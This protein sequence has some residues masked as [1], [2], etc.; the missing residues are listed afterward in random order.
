DPTGAIADARRA[1]ALGPSLHACRDGAALARDLASHEPHGKW[2]RALVRE[3]RR[4]A[5]RLVETRTQRIGDEAIRVADEAAA[6]FSASPSAHASYAMA[7]FLHGG[8]GDAGRSLV[9]AEA[10]HALDGGDSVTEVVRAFASVSTQGFE[11]AQTI[12]EAAARLPD[13]EASASGLV[14][15]TALPSLQLLW[16]TSF[17]LPSRDPG[18]LEL[19]RAAVAAAFERDTR[20]VAV[21]Y[22]ASALAVAGDASGSARAA[23][24]LRWLEP[25]AAE[26]RAQ[27]RFAHDPRVLGSRIADE[28]WEPVHRYIRR[29]KVHKAPIEDGLDGMITGVASVDY[30]AV[31][32]EAA[33]GQPNLDSVRRRLGEQGF[34]LAPAKDEL[35]PGAFDPDAVPLPEPRNAIETAA[36]AL[37]RAALALAAVQTLSWTPEHAGLVALGHVRAA[38][39]AYARTPL[40]HAYRSLALDLLGAHKEAELERAR[41]EELVPEVLVTALGVARAS[42]GERKELAKRLRAQAFELSR[43][44]K[45]VPLGD[46]SGLDLIVG[47]LDEERFTVPSRTAVIVPASLSMGRGLPEGWTI[48]V[49]GEEP[50]L[51]GTAPSSALAIDLGPGDALDMEVKG[52][53]GEGELSVELA[54]ERFTVDLRRATNR[55]HIPIA[56][57]LTEPSH[58]TLAVTRGKVAIAC[59]FRRS[60]A[61]PDDVALLRR[62]LARACT[63]AG[64]RPREADLKVRVARGEAPCEVAWFAASHSIRLGDPAAIPAAVDATFARLLGRAP[65]P[66]EKQRWVDALRADADPARLPRVLCRSREFHERNGF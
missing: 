39:N 43:S 49:R 30:A 10:A 61:T 52:G 57:G 4:A 41:F 13:R 5:N 32:L 36:S 2:A 31:G 33:L 3:A 60:L 21:A 6:V 15:R 8:E 47:T 11:K 38:E 24:E 19:A 27:L 51:V 18:S 42:G 23:N 66:A 25:R 44:A 35:A 17:A 50:W 46:P 9:E 59:L 53:P 64:E 65:E 62:Q 16:R 63:V 22:L 45:V 20:S 28:P 40:V 56:A 54:G 7:L 55:E 29:F 12:L 48:D 34:G 26:A 37:L 1:A 14:S 58:P